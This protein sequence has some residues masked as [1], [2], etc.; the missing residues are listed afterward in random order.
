MKPILLALPLLALPLLAMSAPGLAKAPETIE[1]TTPDGKTE[2]L[3]CKRI[4][5]TGSRLGGPRVCRTRAEWDADEI[6]ARETTRRMQH[7]RETTHGQ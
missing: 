5:T 1:A 2:K 6:Q 7:S 3:V 4:V